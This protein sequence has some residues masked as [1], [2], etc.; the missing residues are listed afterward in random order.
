[1]PGKTTMLKVSA[2]V[3]QY[4]NNHPD[5]L[6]KCDSLLL[7]LHLEFVCRQVRRIGRRLDCLVLPHTQIPFTLFTITIFISPLFSLVA[8]L[9]SYAR[10]C[11]RCRRC[12][13]TLLSTYTRSSRRLH[14][15]TSSTSRRSHIFCVFVNHLGVRM[16][17][18]SCS[19]ARTC[20]SEPL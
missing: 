2:P 4:H 15:S 9:K 19:H 20:P 18:T 3:S 6:H 5:V 16:I 1:M 12:I 17:F 13:T 11:C 8:L 10:P 14:K 7:S